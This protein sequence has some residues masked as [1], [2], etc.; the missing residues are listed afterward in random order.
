LIKLS[1]PLS[2]PTLGGFNFFSPLASKIHTLKAASLQ[3]LCSRTPLSLARFATVYEPKLKIMPPNAHLPKRYSLESIFNR[4]RSPN[5][6]SAT[7]SA[8]AVL[9]NTFVFSSAS[10]R[11]TNDT[12]FI[13]SQILFNPL[14]ISKSISKSIFYLSLDRYLYSLEWWRQQNRHQEFVKTFAVID[15]TV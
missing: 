7:A 4:S 9:Q 15:S 13:A 11:E 14:S 2:F 3:D 12:D 1:S 10:V 6:K 5:R 8:K